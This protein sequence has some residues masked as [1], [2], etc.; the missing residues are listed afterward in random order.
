VIVIRRSPLPKIVD[1]GLFALLR[2]RQEDQVLAPDASRPG[3]ALKESL[4]VFRRI[5]RAWPGGIGLRIAN[6]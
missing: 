5:A 6:S 1:H 3:D 2:Y 4:I